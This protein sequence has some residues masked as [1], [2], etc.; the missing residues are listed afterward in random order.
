LI[1]YRDLL[2]SIVGATNAFWGS[3]LGL[4]GNGALWAAV[5]FFLG[6]IFSKPLIV[7]PCQ[8]FDRRR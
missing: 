4:V 2:S 3:D 5:G 8:A 6:L 7:G 1:G